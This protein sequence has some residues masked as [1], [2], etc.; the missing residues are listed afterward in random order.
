M[1]KVYKGKIIMKDPGIRVQE[2]TGDIFEGLFIDCGDCFFC[3]E[4]AQFLSK[5]DITDMN[6]S[7]EPLDYNGSVVAQQLMG[8]I[9]ELSQ[10]DEGI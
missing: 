6:L 8:I 5:A 4:T 10:N 3:L 2:S 1:I 7:W 9:N